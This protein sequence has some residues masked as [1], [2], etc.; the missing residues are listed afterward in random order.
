[1][2]RHTDPGA[3]A[4]R[5]RYH[6]SLTRAPAR[7]ACELSRTWKS[8]LDLRRS[9]WGRPRTVPVISTSRPS[10]TAGSEAPIC[11]CATNAAHEYPATRAH[12][13]LARAF[14]IM[15]CTATGSDPHHIAS[16]NTGSLSST[17]TPA[18]KRQ[19]IT[20]TVTSRGADSSASGPAAPGNV[21]AEYETWIMPCAQSSAVGQGSSYVETASPSIVGFRLGACAIQRR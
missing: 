21:D 19:A 7:S 4:T 6:E 15:S 3:G 14:M 2:R 17:A 12:S 1:M 11:R 18:T 9:A 13:G 20:S 5:T 8:N 16:G 10:T